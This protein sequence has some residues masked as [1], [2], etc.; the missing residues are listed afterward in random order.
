MSNSVSF[1]LCEQ[2]ICLHFSLTNSNAV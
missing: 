2:Y 1:D